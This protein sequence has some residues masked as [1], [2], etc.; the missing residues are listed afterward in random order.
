M[1]SSARV[2]VPAMGRSL[3]ASRKIV[4][5]VPARSKAGAAA[6]VTGPSRVLQAHG[7]RG[8]LSLLPRP[9]LPR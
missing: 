1:K 7:T 2:K 9:G 5:A 6:A 8:Q 4:L 3:A